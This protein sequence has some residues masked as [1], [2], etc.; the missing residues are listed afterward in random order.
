M[1]PITREEKYLAAAAGYDITPPEPFTRKEFFLAKLAGMDVPEM[2]TYSRE[3][4][5]L[6][7]VARRSPGAVIEPL[8]ITENGT[9]TAPEGVDGYSPVTVEVAAL[10]GGAGKWA[11]GTFEGNNAPITINHN[12]GVVP[13]LIIIKVQ[14]PNTLTSEGLY[15]CVGFL[16][17]KK[18][19]PVLGGGGYGWSLSAQYG[20]H[21]SYVTSFVRQQGV[22]IPIDSADGDPIKNA[23]ETSFTVG[24]TTTQ[25]YPAKGTY[26][27]IAIGGLA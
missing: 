21:A 10:G 7:E 1:E 19:I 18:E 23:N 26:N 17:E 3:E 27:W 4:M 9:Y 8:M 11:W 14:K 16:E 5:F 6:E 13:D 24:S 20:K 15:E 12:L 25:F 22:T 2:Q